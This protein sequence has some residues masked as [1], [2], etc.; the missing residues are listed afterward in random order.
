MHKEMHVWRNI[1]ARSL[2]YGRTATQLGCFNRPRSLSVALPP[3]TPQELYG[4]RILVSGDY[5]LGHDRLPL[6]LAA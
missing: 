4:D 6:P 5:R 3:Q 2:S 1:N